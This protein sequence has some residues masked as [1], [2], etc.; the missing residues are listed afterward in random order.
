[1]SQVMPDCALSVDGL[2]ELPK[3]YQVPPNTAHTLNP[4]AIVVIRGTDLTCIGFKS[5]HWVQ[6]PGSLREDRF[7]KK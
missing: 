6:Q 2:G 4:I 3:K 1:M 5:L 7:G